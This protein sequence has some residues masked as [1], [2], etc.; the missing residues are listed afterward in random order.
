MQH[1][2]SSFSLSSHM[3]TLQPKTPLCRSFMFLVFVKVP[4]LVLFV[5]FFLFFFFLVQ[6]RLFT[7]LRNKMCLKTFLTALEVSS[8]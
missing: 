5:G 8:M 1:Y 4:C 3:T 2:R 7:Y 6:P